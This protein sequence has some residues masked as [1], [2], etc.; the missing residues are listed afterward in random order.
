MAQTGSLVLSP[1][2]SLDSLVTNEHSL[3]PSAI[4]TTY[5]VVTAPL[6]MPSMLPWN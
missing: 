4:F 2:R 6:I 1:R 3:V 5:Y